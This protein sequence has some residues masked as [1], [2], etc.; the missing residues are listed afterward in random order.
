MPNRLVPNWSKFN[1]GRG[2]F[3]CMA[4]KPE[5]DCFRIHLKMQLQPEPPIASG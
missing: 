5:L 4:N 3:T 2:Q 1:P